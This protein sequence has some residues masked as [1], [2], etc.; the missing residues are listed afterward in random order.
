VKEKILGALEHIERTQNV[1]ILFAAEAGSRAWGFESPDSDWDVRFVY[2][3]D[4]NWYLTITEGRD[5]LDNYHSMVAGTEFDDPLLDITGWDLKKTF[6]MLRKSNPQLLEWLSSPS[7][8]IDRAATD[9]RNAA[10]RALHLYPLQAHYHGMAK[11]NFREYLQGP[12]VR[13]KKYLYVIR[14]LMAA[15]WIRTFKTMPPVEFD[16][17]VRGVL[18]TYDNPDELN[19]SVQKLLAVKRKSNEVDAA[20]ADP[21]L[22]AWIEQQLKLGGIDNDSADERDIDLDYVFRYMLYHYA[23]SN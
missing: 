13:Y 12:E 11:G 20:P 22:H 21:V 6:K 7:I 17:I 4:F 1:R 14:P 19:A 10:T 5:V 18:N 9:L 8:Y 15:T 2:V 16:A 23:A 3:R